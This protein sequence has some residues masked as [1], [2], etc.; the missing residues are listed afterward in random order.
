MP[1]LAADIHP[2]ETGINVRGVRMVAFLF[3][4]ASSHALVIPGLGP[5]IH[6]FLSSIPKAWIPAPSAGMTA[7]CA[8]GSGM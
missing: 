4:L 1:I 8:S 2:W 3:A 7:E 5:G 6:A